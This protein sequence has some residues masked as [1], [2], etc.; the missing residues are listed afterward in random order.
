[1]QIVFARR[2][3]RSRHPSNPDS[4]PDQTNIHLHVSCKYSI[5][6]SFQSRSRLSTLTEPSTRLYQAPTPIGCSLLKSVQRDRMLRL[7]CCPPLVFGACRNV[8]TAFVSGDSCAAKKRNYS[9]RIRV[10]KYFSSQI[11]IDFRG[12]PAASRIYETECP[13][14]EGLQAARTLAKRRL[15]TCTSTTPPGASSRALSS[16][17]SPSTFTAPGPIRRRASDVLATSAAALST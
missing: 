3:F 15:P 9:E 17:R 8:R 6:S 5:S 16:R 14:T 10:V 2:N 11:H 7:A 13:C 12:A 4:R 1:M